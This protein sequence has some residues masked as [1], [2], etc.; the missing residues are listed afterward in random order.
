MSAGVGKEIFRSNASAFDAV[1]MEV[2]AGWGSDAESY[3]SFLPCLLQ[4]AFDTWS[5]I[6]LCREQNER[7]ESAGRRGYECGGARQ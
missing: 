5:F 2:S 1:V 7:L 6:P 4:R 3:H